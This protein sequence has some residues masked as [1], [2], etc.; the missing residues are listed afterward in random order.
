MEASE[1]SGLAKNEDFLRNVLEPE[2]Q[3]GETASLLLW[4]EIELHAARHLKG[5]LSVRALRLQHCNSSGILKP[6]CCNLIEPAFAPRLSARFLCTSAF[7]EVLREA[8]SI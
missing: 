8:T 5:F 2:A 6:S 1:G 4:W 3:T 7:S